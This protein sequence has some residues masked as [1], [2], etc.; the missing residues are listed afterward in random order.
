MQQE[1]SYLE[2]EQ[3]I[4]KMTSAFATRNTRIGK[5]VIANLGDRLPL[6]D[7]AG[8]VLISL[9]RL[10]W[11]DSLAFCWAVEKTIPNYMLRE[12]RRITSIALYKRLIDKGLTPGADFSVDAK[13]SVLM[14]DRAKST[15]LK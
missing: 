10:A 3:D 8:V 7:I 13:G 15:V 4:S 2:L 6:R 11:T 12:I 9:E 14:G 5:E 1:V